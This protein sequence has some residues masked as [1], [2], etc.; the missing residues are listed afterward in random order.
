MANNGD[1][2]DGHIGLTEGLQ[3]E[4]ARI[5]DSSISQA[6]LD[7]QIRANMEIRGVVEAVQRY[8]STLSIGDKYQMLGRYHQNEK[9]PKHPSE[10]AINDLLAK[11]IIGFCP[12]AELKRLVQSQNAI[13]TGMAHDIRIQQAKTK[14]IGLSSLS[15]GDSFNETAFGRA[16]G[17]SK[18][19]KNARGVFHD[20]TDETP[21]AIFNKKV[22]EMAYP[23]LTR[24]LTDFLM[25]MTNAELSATSDSIGATFDDGTPR[26]LVIKY[27]C[28]RI[29]LYASLM[30]GKINEKTAGVF[31]S[32]FSSDQ[33]DAMNDLLRYTSFIWLTG[34]SN[35]SIYEIR[36]RQKDAMKAKK[37]MGLRANVEAKKASAY[38]IKEK[39]D[40][41]L[42]VKPTGAITNLF[43]NGLAR[44][45]GISGWKAIRIAGKTSITGKAGIADNVIKKVEDAV[46]SMSDVDV[47]EQLG[48]EAT[49]DMPSNRAILIR[50]LE[51]EFGEADTNIRKSNEY[52]N[53]AKMHLTE[54]QQNLYDMQMSATSFGHFQDIHR[55][56]QEFSEQTPVVTFNEAGKLTSAAIFKAV[57]VYVVGYASDE[58]QTEVSPD[59]TVR[60]HHVNALG[61]TNVIKR[62]SANMTA[63]EQLNGVAAGGLSGLMSSLW[64]RTSAPKSP[65]ELANDSLFNGNPLA[66][67]ENSELR[68]AN[69]D[70]PIANEKFPTNSFFR[71]A[72]N[73]KH[74]KYGDVMPVA[75]IAN[76]LFEGNP[77][78]ASL[79]SHL[80]NIETAN[81]ATASAANGIYGFLTDTLPLYMLGLQSVMGNNVM[82]ATVPAVMGA[83]ATSDTITSTIRSAL[84]GINKSQLGGTVPL[85]TGGTARGRMATGGVTKALSFSGARLAAMKRTDNVSSIIT[86]DSL[87]RRPNP[88]AVSVNWDRQSIAVKP[89]AAAAT[90][91]TATSPVGSG[92]TSAQVTSRLTSTQ[93][94][95]PMAVD[96]TSGLVT[97]KKELDD[98]IESNDN[99]AVKVYSINDGLSSK[100]KVGDSEMSIYDML[101]AM[102]SS[103]ENSNTLLEK[104]VTLNTA[105]AAAPKTSSSSSGVNGR[106]TITDAANGSLSDFLKGI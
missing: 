28:N 105:I 8:V 62:K 9:I 30:S 7:Y 59:G 13:A 29:Q 101:G 18:H 4:E 91:V 99:S 93:R 70:F 43:R 66:F 50:Q 57:P 54:S 31:R 16:Y 87:N 53:L 49:P 102:I 68:K 97:Y 45:H 98:G 12:A 65:A 11:A 100:V 35:A 78:G 42:G 32:S 95:T 89:L 67:G 19:A 37:Q 103:S 20:S 27:I 22:T 86:G 82:A 77:Y 34:E 21:S 36:A 15:S 72:L 104:I 63:E 61:V 51:I 71:K 33:M 88:E 14:A 40:G 41:T 85:A 58:D 80:S 44:G 26:L 38:S 73:G 6:N 69:S 48:P 46:S 23:K 1:V 47:I 106:N 75:D 5:I 94:S 81:K 64:K 92:D 60:T 2:G 56:Q 55:D 52:R 24:E 10:S 17:L 76:P 84:S 3:S 90:G 96:L 83:S 25:T 39:G 79:Y 74:M